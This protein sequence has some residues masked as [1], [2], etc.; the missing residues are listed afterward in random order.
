MH[1]RYLHLA[2]GVLIG[3]CVLDV[4]SPSE[5][6]AQA[7]PRAVTDRAIAR[8]KALYEGRGQCAGCHGVRGEGTEVGE[9]LA[10]GTWKLGDG[11]YDWLTKVIRHSGI[12]ARGRDGDPLP[13]RGPTLLSEREVREVAAY[14]WSISR[15]RTSSGP[16]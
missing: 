8:G 3:A 7:R 13:M 11:S 12:A 16:S 9:P 15:Q 6:Q 10:A 2:V 14:V 4:A 5:G 1:I